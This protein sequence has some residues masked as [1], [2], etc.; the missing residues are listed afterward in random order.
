[1]IRLRDPKF[2]GALP[3][4]SG[5]F[6]NLNGSRIRFLGQCFIPRASRAWEIN[7]EFLWKWSDVSEKNSPSARIAGEKCKSRPA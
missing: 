2:S 3:L 1:M 5:S 7:S 6:G 4:P